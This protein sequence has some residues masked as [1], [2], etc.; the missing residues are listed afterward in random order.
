MEHSKEWYVAETGNHQ[1]LICS[2]DT[3]ENIAVS[4]D[5]THAPL[6]AASPL[7]LQACKCALADI[8]GLLQ[9]CCLTEP[10]EIPVHI[11]E[12]IKE[13]KYAIKQAKGE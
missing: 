3:G 5:K 12:T 4:Y 1:G 6:L 13:L 9:L 7:L 2:E 8:E 10:D 11:Q